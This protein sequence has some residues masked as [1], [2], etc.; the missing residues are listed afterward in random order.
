MNCLKTQLKEIVNNPS[1]VKLGHVLLHVKSE[2]VG[3]V[4]MRI[5][6]GATL[7]IIGSGYMSDNQATLDT[8][9]LTTYSY[10]SNS[11]KIM[12]FSAGDYLLD[13]DNKYNIRYLSNRTKSLSDCLDVDLSDIAGCANMREVSLAN[14]KGNISVFEDM[15][16]LSIVAINN[17]MYVTGNLISLANKNLTIFKIQSS[18]VIG[19]IEELNLENVTIFG[20]TNS[21]NITGNISALP[22]NQLTELGIVGSSL[23]GTLSELGKKISSSLSTLFLMDKDNNTYMTTISGSVESFVASAVANGHTSKV[24]TMRGLFNGINTFG[25]TAYPKQVHTELHW[26]NGGDKIYVQ[27]GASTSS[28]NI[29]CKGYSITEI[30]EWQ[31]QGYTVT[32]VTT[33]EVYPP[34]NS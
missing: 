10:S 29:H 17:G 9:R 18:S 21:S 33:G 23:Y 2:S 7:N 22:D 15:P 14:I 3:T 25:G 26:E 34:T 11:E 30:A 27:G 24:I 6:G 5:Q 12:Y 13:I 31:A 4:P 32:D 19:N 8:D 1:L 16:N 28:K 20:A